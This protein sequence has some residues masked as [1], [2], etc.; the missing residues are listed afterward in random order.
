MAKVQK[1]V[2]QLSLPDRLRSRKFWLA[3]GA[4][5]TFVANGQYNEAMGVVVAYLGFQGASDA[6]EKYQQLPPK[7]KEVDV[8][9]DTDDVDTTKIVSGS[10]TQ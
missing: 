1:V 8:Y 10:D 5:I 4:F 3:V 2:E 9:D 7:P 6:I